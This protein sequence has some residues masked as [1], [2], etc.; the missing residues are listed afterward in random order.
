MMKKPKLNPVQRD[1][2]KKMNRL[3]RRLSAKKLEDC[4]RT[5]LVDVFYCLSSVSGEVFKS[6]GTYQADY[7]GQ[8]RRLHKQTF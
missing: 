5:D 3:A 2:L 4:S 6:D 1:L 8:E 7:S